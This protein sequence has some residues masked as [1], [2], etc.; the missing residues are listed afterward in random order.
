MRFPLLVRIPMFLLLLVLFLLVLLFIMSVSVSVKV[1]TF[2]TIFLLHFRV[3]DPS[4]A[5]KNRHNRGTLS[6]LCC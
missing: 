5:P 3:S 6:K 4:H 1:F 2:Q